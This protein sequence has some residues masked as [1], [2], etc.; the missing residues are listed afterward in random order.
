MRPSQIEN[1]NLPAE[2][3]QELTSND[4]K[5]LDSLML[6]K[7][8]GSK[9]FVERGHNKDERLR[10]LRA[11]RK[12]KVELEALHWKGKDYLSQFVYD[13]VMNHESKHLSK[14]QKIDRNSH[15]NQPDF[16]LSE[17]S[18]VDDFDDGIS[19]ITELDTII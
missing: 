17:R 9:P 19:D 2:V 1:M 4:T 3:F 5:R 11:M 6:S 8:S 10:D 15:P 12:Y 7:S 18:F 16:V 13:A 14:G